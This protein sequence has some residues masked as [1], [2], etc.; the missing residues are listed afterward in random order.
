LGKIIDEVGLKR[1]M[2]ANAR[3]KKQCEINGVKPKSVYLENRAACSKKSQPTGE[4]K[5]MVKRNDK[6]GY[7]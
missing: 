7:G 2:K 5:E 3:V 1:A 4:A 6:K